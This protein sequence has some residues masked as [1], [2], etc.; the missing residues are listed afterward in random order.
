MSLTQIQIVDPT[1]YLTTGTQVDKDGTITSIG[2]EGEGYILGTDW[3]AI[4]DWNGATV[5]Y[6]MTLFREQKIDIQ[7]LEMKPIAS[8]G[9]DIIQAEVPSFYGKSTAY[10]REYSILTTKRLDRANLIDRIALFSAPL[11]FDAYRVG[12]VGGTGDRQPLITR[13]QCL[14]GRSSLFVSDSSLPVLYGFGRQLSNYDLNMGTEVGCDALYYYRVMFVY[15]D[16]QAAN[17]IFWDNS[18]RTTILTLNVRDDADD[19]QIATGMIRAYQAP[20]GPS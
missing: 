15:G 10:M 13:D 12:G 1:A 8:L 4:M 6:D 16:V 18:A 2:N 5:N 14:A 3:Y 17:Q 19:T 7:G 9:M 20:Q 11:P